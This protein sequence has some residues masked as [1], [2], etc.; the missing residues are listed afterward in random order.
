MGAAKET[1]V[2]GQVKAGTLPVSKEAI[3][4]GHFRA[5]LLGLGAIQRPGKFRAGVAGLGNLSHLWLREGAWE[6]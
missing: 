3:C 2:L 4:R 5:G 6:L 1:A